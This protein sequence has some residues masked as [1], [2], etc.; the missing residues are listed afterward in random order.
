VIGLHYQYETLR[1]YA[2]LNG[3]P[4]CTGTT[5]KTLT[6]GTQTHIIPADTLVFVNN[7]AVQ[8]DEATWGSNNLTWRPQRW[9]EAATDTTS[10]TPIEPSM[11]Y[12]PWASG[13]RVCPGKK[14]SQVEHTAAIACL[15]H[16]YKVEPVLEEG[17]SLAMAKMR[18]FCVLQDS[19]MA[20]A[21]RMNRP[22]KMRV[23]W[24]ADGSE[25]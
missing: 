19:D 1:L 18:L 3:V 14:F 20:L 25:K 5:P 9:L 7:A 21:M 10:Y 13:P 4:R 24:V 15:F 16:K 6:L 12:I 22:E 23:R 11:N 8:M 2:P 17:E